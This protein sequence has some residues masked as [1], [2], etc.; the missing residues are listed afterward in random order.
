MGEMTPGGRVYTL[1]RP[2]PLN[3][4]HTI[5]FLLHLLGVAG[6]RL[7]VI[8]DG[9]PI[10]R[11]AEVTEFVADTRGRVWSEAL[12][13]YAPDLN[14]SDKGGTTSRMS[15]CATWCAATWTS[16]TRNSTSP[17]GGCGRSLNWSDPRSLRLG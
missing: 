2:E 11:R 1:I 5:E 14:P 9:S 8:W 12:P 10:H 15:S 17:S 6:E 16:C 13:R 7:L 4:V 3:G